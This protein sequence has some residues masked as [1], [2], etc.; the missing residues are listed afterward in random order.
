[1]EVSVSS[2]RE[3]SYDIETCCIHGDPDRMIRDHNNAVSFPIYQTACFSHLNPGHNP[4]G[5]DYSRESNPT[6]TR[7][8]QVM[9]ALEDAHASMAMTSGMAAVSAVFELFAPGDRVLCSED[10]YGGVTRLH[11]IIST[12]NGV[13]IDYVDMSDLEAVEE[14]VRPE[15]R[16]LY[17]ET[18]TNPT[19][20]VA[21]Q[22]GL[23]E[24]AHRHDCLLIADNT[25]MSPYFQKPLHL[26]ADLVIHSGTKFLSGHN[27]TVSGFICSG[28]PE[29]TDR[30]R[31][32]AKTTGAALAP[33][34]CWLTL[35]GIK[36]LAVRMERQQEN[37]MAVAEWLADQP[38]VAEV[39]Y[40]GLPSH[41]GHELQKSQA[42]GFG[43]MISF[44]VKDR[45]QAVKILHRVK[46]ITFAESLGG[47]ETLI[48]Y[49][50]TQTHA[51]VPERIRERLGINATLLRLSIGL[52]NTRDLLADLSRAM[53]GLR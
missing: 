10:L 32:L 9:S 40:P 53:E 46:L 26:G 37:A 36:T 27:D 15:T 13:A 33:F 8:E 47:T 51:D 7:L 23:V 34:D 41:P 12:K 17:V 39:L 28:R 11:G 24:I 19:M 31:L 1:M 30:L 48:T 5:F 22:R 50:V 42:T 35:R 18:P 4:N 43:S 3:Q 21:D 49:P 25:F 6:R 45:T 52:E 14:A 16:A 20:T 29:L 2:G 44:H 38:G